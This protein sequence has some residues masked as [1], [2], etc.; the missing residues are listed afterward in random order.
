MFQTGGLSRYK[1]QEFASEITKNVL[2]TKGR[3]VVKKKISGMFLFAVLLLALTAC[4]KNAVNQWQEQYD[5]GQ[6]YLLEE[7]YEAAIVAFTEA[8]E[9]DPNEAAAYVGRGDAYIGS[10]ETE[11][12]MALAL[13]DYETARELDETVTDA[14]L[15][16][17]KVYQWRGEYEEAVEILEGGIE[18]TGGDSALEEMLAEFEESS[19]NPYEDENTVFAYS[20]QA[21]DELPEDVQDFI[22]LMATAA[23][24]DDTVAVQEQ[25]SSDEADDY[26]YYTVWNEYKVNIVSIRHEDEYEQGSGDE[27]VI[28]SD[29]SNLVRIEL[30]PENGMGYYL[31]VSVG[32]YYSQVS[33][34]SSQTQY[35]SYDYISCPCESWQWNGVFYEEEYNNYA[36]SSYYA[37][38]GLTIDS[39]SNST[40]ITTGMMVDNL[41]DGTF[42]TTVTGTG[43]DVMGEEVETTESY[44][45]TYEEGVLIESTAS[46]S[47][48]DDRYYGLLGT[49]L[50]LEMLAW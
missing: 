7:D 42:N 46:Y 4:G 19:V 5:L 38:P 13:A 20:Y 17:A 10:G 21:L 36:E 31:S 12:N 50:E 14:Y 11:E 18:K 35:I 28:T 39:D 22:E 45:I 6:K 33:T 2:E 43:E 8:I 49:P 27:H 48:G 37:G 23:I 47:F 25:L 40:S 41:R 44:Y 30:R 29:V 9:I 3:M 26:N 32:T 24:S 34:I 15:G 1:R 16:I